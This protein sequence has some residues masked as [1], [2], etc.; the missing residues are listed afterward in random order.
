[1][2]YPATLT[3]ENE[4]WTVTFRNIPEVITCDDDLQDAL[5]MAQDALIASMDHRTVPL[6]SKAKK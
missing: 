5:N 2:F 1:M 6:P 3:K 4:R